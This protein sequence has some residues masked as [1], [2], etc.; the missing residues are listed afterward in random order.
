MEPR[1]PP[2]PPLPSFL[3]LP[4]PL[5]VHSQLLLT[6]YPRQNS[7]VFSCRV[8]LFAP[9]DSAPVFVSMFCFLL[10]FFSLSSSH[11]LFLPMLSF[12]LLPNCLIFSFSEFSHFLFYP[13]ASFSLSPNSLDFSF[14]PIALFSLSPN[15]LIFSLSQFSHFHLL[16]FSS[17]CGGRPVAVSL[18]VAFA[19][20]R[21][22]RPRRGEPF[23]KAVIGCDRRDYNTTAAHRCYWLYS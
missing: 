7:Y 20:A 19:S 22:A 13:T 2:H 16:A 12:S 23:R 1:P 18:C 14:S 3:P 6:I 4:S 9:R 11:L 8:C 10:L 21:P 5:S 17:R 15:S